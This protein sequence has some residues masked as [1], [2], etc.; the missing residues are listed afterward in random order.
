LCEDVKKRE[1]DRRSSGGIVEAV[2]GKIGPQIHRL[3]AGI[4]VVAVSVVIVVPV[5]VLHVRPLTWRL[6]SS[7]G[8]RTYIADRSPRNFRI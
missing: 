5:V 8:D 1:A 3:R 6:S 2:T 7:P 4:A